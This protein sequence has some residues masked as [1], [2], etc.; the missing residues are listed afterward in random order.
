MPDK[1][2]A[3]KV[4]H[5]ATKRLEN[6]SENFE[7]SISGRLG[8]RRMVNRILAG[9][10]VKPC[11]RECREYGMM[12]AMNL[13]HS[14]FQNFDEL[15]NDEEFVLQIVGITP[16]P[17]EC[18]NYFYQYVNPYLKKKADFRLKFLKEIYLNENVYKLDDINLIV[19]WCGFEKENEIIKN[20]MDFK[21]RLQKR[22]EEIDYQNMIEYVCSGNDEKELHN[23]KVEANNMKVLCENIKKGL[24]EIINTFAGKKIE[25]EEPKDFWAYLCQ[26][27]KNN[28][29]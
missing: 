14:S 6:P 9:R 11:G 28:Q 13:N 15:M 22:L 7:H 4:S 16:N 26:Q 21:A 10:R 27:A 1:K 12:I 20:D 18:E 3:Q 17:T 19:E 5:Q 2:R 23:Y 24:V 29:I 25:D 8:D